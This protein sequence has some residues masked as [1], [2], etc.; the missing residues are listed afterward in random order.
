M[1]TLSANVGMGWLRDYPSFRDFT[2]EHNIVLPQFKKLGQKDSIK[3]MLNKAGIADPGG[4]T[5]PV[6]VDNRT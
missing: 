2:P 5:L 3:A 6:K 1:D 4:L